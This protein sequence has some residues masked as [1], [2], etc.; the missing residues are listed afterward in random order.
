MKEV[1][2]LIYAVFLLKIILKGQSRS[3]LCSH[4]LASDFFVS[5]LKRKAICRFQ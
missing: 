2:N 5:S 3:N 4:G 1:K